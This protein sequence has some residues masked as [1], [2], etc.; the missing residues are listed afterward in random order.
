MRRLFLLAGIWG[1]SFLLIKVSV[2]GMPPGAVA[3]T[4]V[5][6]GM[7]VL[8]VV[9]RLKGLGLPTGRT[10]WRHFAVVGLFGSAVPFT[11]L[12]WGEQ[13][14]ASAL[15]A[16]L[17]ASTPLFAAL[18]AACFLGQR[19]RRSQSVGL[20]LGFVGVGVAAGLGASDLSGSSLAGEA[21]AVGAGA[22]YA[23]ATVYAKRH[24]GALSPLVAA[25]GQLVMATVLAL[26]VALVT[27]VREGLD[28]T[29]RR[30]LAVCLLGI[31]GTGVAY[32]LLYRVIADLGPTMASAVTYLVPVMA[33][34]AGLL[35]LH[36]PFHLRLVAGGLLIVGGIVLLNGQGVRPRE[37]AEAVPH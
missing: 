27:T 15:A 33:V 28:L 30:L 16:V 12:A 20:L 24:L 22:C 19:L 14:I 18:M 1:W 31:V 32:V 17:N 26:P 37:R 34:T 36:E 11:M 3:F 29:P 21:A 35:F 10:A 2:G 7:V 9:V 4:R 6:L 8:L 25:A 23:V 13:H 5:A